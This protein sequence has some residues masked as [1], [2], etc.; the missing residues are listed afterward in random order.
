MR[1]MLQPVFLSVIRCNMPGRKISVEVRARIIGFLENGVTADQS[2]RQAGVNRATG[3]RKIL[4]VSKQVP[5][6][7]D[8]DMANRNQQLQPKIGLSN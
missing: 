1:D 3:F 2:A 6:R 7:I 8:Q 4:S 5:G